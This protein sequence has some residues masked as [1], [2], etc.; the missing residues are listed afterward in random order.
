V[1]MSDRCILVVSIRDTNY[2][3]SEPLINY[4]HFNVLVKIVKITCQI[5]G[6]LQEIISFFLF[7]RHHIMISKPSIWTYIFSY[8]L[9]PMD[10]LLC[11]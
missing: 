2:W 3:N 7:L 6:F 11:I 9:L 4:F 8:A 5:V 10:L 1:I